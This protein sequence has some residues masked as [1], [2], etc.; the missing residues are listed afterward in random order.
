VDI[1]I[2]IIESLCCTLETNTTLTINCTPL[3]KEKENVWSEKPHEVLGWPES[4]FTMEKPKRNVWP[5]QYLGPN[6]GIPCACHQPFIFSSASFWLDLT[7]SAVT[8]P[9]LGPIARSQGRKRRGRQRTQWLDG[10]T[11]SRDMRL[12]KLR[13]MVKDREAWSAAVH[14]VAESDTTERSN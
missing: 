2:C 4:S 6:L 13:E 3:T 8:K 12:S 14:G 7:F 11:N 9:S 1:C 5:A 10:I